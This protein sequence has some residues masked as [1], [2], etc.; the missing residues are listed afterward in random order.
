MKKDINKLPKENIDLIKSTLDRILGDKI[1]KDKNKVISDF[2]KMR[3]EIDIDSY[4]LCYISQ[5]LDLYDYVDF[6]KHLTVEINNFKVEEPNTSS[7]IES[8][9]LYKILNEELK[10][11]PIV[12][13][14]YHGRKK[15]LDIIINILEWNEF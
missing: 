9:P 2:R 10:Y 11:E 6:F 1:K 12:D 14:A 5:D 8:E 15:L 3:D 13:N 7:A 4:Y